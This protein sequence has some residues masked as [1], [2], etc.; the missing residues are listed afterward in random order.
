MVGGRRPDECGDWAGTEVDRGVEPELQLEPETEPELESESG[1][2][3]V[4]VAA[5]AAA[6]GGWGRV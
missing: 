5:R 4:T 2:A 1:L 3:V 6:S